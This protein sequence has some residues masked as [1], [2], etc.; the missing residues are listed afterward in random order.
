MPLTRQEIEQGLGHLH[1]MDCRTY[2]AQ[3]ELVPLKCY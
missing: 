1:S 2:Q 3:D